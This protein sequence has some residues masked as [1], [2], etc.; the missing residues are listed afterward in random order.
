MGRIKLL[1]ILLFTGSLSSWGC[2]WQAR[3]PKNVYDYV[4]NEG[5]LSLTEQI[6]EIAA[7]RGAALPVLLSFKS[8]R[9]Y[10]SPYVGSAWSI[11]PFDSY[12]EKLDEKTLKVV[13]PDGVISYFILDKLGTYG[14][15]NNMRAEYVNL[16]V[17]VIK[18]P[19]GQ[20]FRY[21]KGR[22]SRLTTQ[23]L[24]TIDF[25]RENRECTMTRG[26]TILAHVTREKDEYCSVKVGDQ[27]ININLGRVPVV[28]SLAGT[29]V[30]SG[31]TMAPTTIIGSSGK[32]SNIEHIVDSKLNGIINF[33]DKNGYRMSYSF[34]P[35]SGIVQSDGY[36][37]YKFSQT[38]NDLPR[39]S[40][41]LE[42]TSINGE[43]QRHSEDYRQGKIIDEDGLKKTIDY[44]HTGGKLAGKKRK[45]ELFEN[46]RLIDKELFS[47]DERG[48]RIR[49]VLNDKNVTNYEVI[50]D[51]GQNMVI[52]LERNSNADLVGIT[53]QDNEGKMIEFFDLRQRCGNLF[54][55]YAHMPSGA[56]GI[57]YAKYFP[58]HLLEI[59]HKYTNTDKKL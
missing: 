16:D 27:A 33:G 13:E 52:T 20:S 45:I 6:A 35:L 39:S 55:S 34:D 5:L 51:A 40:F 28:S 50:R 53:I 59:A 48:Y 10:V 44:Y 23:T 24:G 11:F 15:P 58:A 12:A 3:I 47:Y 4:N 17:L 57:Y 46:D 56:L 9:I 31:F 41:M 21:T 14:G 18:G 7:Q 25:K 43:R 42:R 19:C 1:I 30:I 26:N 37:E 8:R 32:V 49:S 54:Q 38:S 22:L 2:E 36:W 29:K